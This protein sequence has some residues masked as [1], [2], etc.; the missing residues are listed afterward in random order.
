MPNVK[1]A[2]RFL[3]FKPFM[4]MSVGIFILIIGMN[5]R[6]AMNSWTE[7]AKED[8]KV[9]GNKLK[10]AGIGA[11]GGAALGGAGAAA[12]GGVGI[13]ACGTGI[14]LPAG[15]MMIAGALLG[16]GVGGMAG[17]MTGKPDGVNTVIRE[18]A[19]VTPAYDAKLWIAAI[20]IGIFLIFLGLCDMWKA[21]KGNGDNALKLPG[22]QKGSG[23]NTH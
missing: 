9:P 6:T 22:T 17:A 4:I 7:I 5:M 1:N 11:A 18:I 20:C 21:M 12:L 16:A 13:V 10:R 14:G 19:H 23:T 8:I 2:S 15:I 3:L